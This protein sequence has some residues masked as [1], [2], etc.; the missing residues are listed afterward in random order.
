MNPYKS[1]ITSEKVSY[2][3]LFHLTACHF[4]QFFSQLFFYAQPMKM[5]SVVFTAYLL[6]LAQ[7]VHLF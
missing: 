3:V 6:A 5:A 4:K 1:S 2:L 7:R